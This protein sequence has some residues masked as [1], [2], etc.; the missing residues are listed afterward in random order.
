[1]IPIKIVAYNLDL[2]PKNNLNCEG[3][4]VDLLIYIF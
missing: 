3:L 4:E 1:M 2:S